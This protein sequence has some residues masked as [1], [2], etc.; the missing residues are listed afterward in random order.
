MD[1]N[2]D[3]DLPAALADT[4]VLPVLHQMFAVYVVACN[5]P[6][7]DPWDGLDDHLIA[8]TPDDLLD[9]VNRLASD[10]AEIQVSGARLAPPIFWEF[11]LCAGADPDQV[12]RARRARRHL[13][14]RCAGR[15]GQPIEHW[16][17]A[18]AIARALGRKTGGVLLDVVVN[19]VQAP[20]SS[21][22]PVDPLDSARRHALTSWTWVHYS[23][24]PGGTYWMT[25]DGLERFGLPTL[26]LAGVPAARLQQCHHL[27]MG[28]AHRLVDQ[29]AA[30]IGHL[31]E[32][33]R[34]REVPRTWA[35]GGTDV[36]GAY[37]PGARLDVHLPTTT[38]MLEEM[39]NDALGGRPMLQVRLAGW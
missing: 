32:P 7:G 1:K 9:D 8:L 18:L 33:P 4:L 23:P 38:M 20:H 15:A 13:L 6:P 19:R 24:E 31:V 21:T 5:A 29:Q 16:W 14:V 11:A 17:T 30:A 25:V 3:S 39:A 22:D 2:L 12:R 36:A 37:P 28:L 34:L 26:S 10:S 27:L 35:I